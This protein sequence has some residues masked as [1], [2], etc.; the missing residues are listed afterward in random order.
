MTDKFVPDLSER[1][2]HPLQRLKV[3]TADCQ[4]CIWL[5]RTCSSAVST[6]QSLQWPS[7][8]LTDK[9]VSGCSDHVSHSSQLLEV[10][11]DL[12]VMLTDKFAPCFSE[13]VSHSSQQLKV[14]PKGGRGSLMFSSCLESQGCHLIPFS[15]SS[16]VLLPS[17]SFFVPFSDNGP[18]F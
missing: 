1:I 3:L 13:R 8:M 9:L 17:C 2:P 5:Q 6:P 14:S 4:G 11:S 16:L 18:F 7:C 10:L 15:I 12:P